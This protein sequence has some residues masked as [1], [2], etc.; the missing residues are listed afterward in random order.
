MIDNRLF[1][2]KAPYGA[3]ILSYDNKSQLILM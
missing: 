2:L 3:L 1:S